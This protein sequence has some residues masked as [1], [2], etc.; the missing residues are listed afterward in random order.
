MPVPGVVEKAGVVAD[1]GL[2]RTPTA[3]ALVLLQFGV[4]PVQ[5]T[6]LL[7]LVTLLN[8]QPAGG[9]SAGFVRRLE[10]HELLVICAI[11]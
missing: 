8:T 9:G 10:S 3:L 4:P 5:G 1:A 7:P 6:E 2:T 11:L